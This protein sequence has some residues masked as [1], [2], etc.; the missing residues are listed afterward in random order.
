MAV[1]A[2]LMLARSHFDLLH[3]FREAAFQVVSIQ[4]NTGFVSADFDA[5]NTFARTLL[6]VLMFVGGCAG[7]TA[8]G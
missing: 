3:A 4:T 8:G 7:S 1:T 2:G 5:W 6:I